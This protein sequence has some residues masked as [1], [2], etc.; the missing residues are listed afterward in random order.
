MKILL[1]SWPEEEILEQ[2]NQTRKI[3]LDPSI[4]RDSAIV[5]HTLHERLSCLSD[6]V[7]ALVIRTLSRSAQGSAIWTK[8]T[9]ELI[10]VRQIKALAPMQ[11]FLEKM[12]L[13]KQLS[14]LSHTLLLQDSSNDSENVELIA[15]ALKI[16]AVAC[17]PL[18]IQELSWAVA[19][20][21]CRHEIK[22]IITAAIPSQAWCL[23]LRT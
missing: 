6:D 11:L 15:M 23:V 10:E 5:R 19:L 9:V 7:R 2:L 12:L 8:M 16:L 18:S 17:R 14:E 22:M 13:P 1:S 20:A 21:A 4:E 3:T